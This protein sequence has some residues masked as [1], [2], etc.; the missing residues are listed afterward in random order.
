LRIDGEIRDKIAS[1]L[2]K[3]V[4]FEKTVTDLY[5]NLTQ[6][7]DEINKRM[8][9]LSRQFQ[10]ER[11]LRSKLAALLQVATSDIE[12]VEDCLQCIWYG[13]VTPRHAARLASMAALDHT[14][15]FWLD[16]YVSVPHGLQL[17]YTSTI[18]SNAN[19]TVR[20]EQE[21]NIVQDGINEFLLHLGHPTTA[22][23][24]EKDV[25]FL[26]SHECQQCALFV[27]LENDLYRCVKA[28]QLTCDDKSA[29]YTTDER[30]QTANRRVCWNQQIKIDEQRLTL[31]EIILDLSSDKLDLDSLLLKRELEGMR[32]TLDNPAIRHRGH[33]AGGM[34]LQNELQSAQR[35]LTTFIQDT[36]LDMAVEFTKP[37]NYIPWTILLILTLTVMFLISVIVWKCRNV[38]SPA[39][40]SA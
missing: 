4:A 23:I 10:Q 21:Y 5:M 27:H 37:T 26:S 13:E 19:V 38:S 40:Q 2:T 30:L 16:I 15:H 34:K 31:K 8:D 11:Q 33:Q 22:P 14:P 35:D 36:K 25:V 32:A 1:T 20:P 39:P 7:E 12:D 18:Y 17:M 6:E 29:N 3:Q 9:S 24:T 28:G